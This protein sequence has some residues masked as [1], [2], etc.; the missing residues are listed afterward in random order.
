MALT[1]LYSF[2]D[3]SWLVFLHKGAKVQVK[4]VNTDSPQW[5]PRAE[6]Q[7][8]WFGDLGLFSLA[9]PEDGSREFF[10][11]VPLLSYK[12][13]L[14]NL[15]CIPL[16]CC[17]GPWTRTKLFPAFYPGRVAWD[18]FKCYSSVL[19]I[20]SALGWESSLLPLGFLTLC[21]CPSWITWW[22]R[23]HQGNLLICK[24]SH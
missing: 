19:F 13:L 9:S 1:Y 7:L 21:P 10:Q 8:A 2:L 18:L 23:A 17:G 6:L 20:K 16:N 3:S 15:H 11:K 12:N 14:Q 5:R 24:A 22:S 4:V